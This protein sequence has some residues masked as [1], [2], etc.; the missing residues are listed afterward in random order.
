MSLPPRRTRRP[1]TQVR[2]FHPGR[3]G[4]PPTG[5][6]TAA[7]PCQHSWAGIDPRDNRLRRIERAIPAGA[8][9]RVEQPSLE[10][11]KQER[12]QRVV[13]APF[14]GEVEEVVERRNSLIA[15]QIRRQCSRP[16]ETRHCRSR[17]HLGVTRFRITI[18]PRTAACQRWRS[19]GRY[20]ALA[21][22][23]RPYPSAIPRRRSAWVPSITPPSEVIRQQRKA[24]LTSLRAT[25]GRSNGKGI[26]SFTELCHPRGA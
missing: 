25:A 16:V 5:S 10:V 23:G 14:E 26:S 1:E 11:L 2:C 21:P 17:R 12:P 24:V 18:L 8:D 7:R 19:R 6:G 20:S 3:A 13:A 9:A 22:T 4:R 15:S